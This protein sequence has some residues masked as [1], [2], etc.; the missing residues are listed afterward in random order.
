[1]SSIIKIANEDTLSSRWV[2][3]HDLSC[4]KNVLSKRISNT[5]MPEKATV[6]ASRATLEGKYLSYMV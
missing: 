3:D 4:M 6:A 2:I 5:F 1:M